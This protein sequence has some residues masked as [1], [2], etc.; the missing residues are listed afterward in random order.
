[1]VEWHGLR[2][3]RRLR[4]AESREDPTDAFGGLDIPVRKSE[5]K[6]RQGKQPDGSAK[7]RELK[8]AAV[9]SAE[10]HNSQDVLERD[11][12]PVSYTSAVESIATRDTDMA[13]SR[14]AR[15]ILREL[16]RRGF[17]DVERS[18]VLG[19]SYALDLELYVEHLPD[20][21]QIVDIAGTPVSTLPRRG[22]PSATRV[23]PGTSATS[24]F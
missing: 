15:R 4:T 8:L 14:F 12:G 19:D 17:D 5:T 21:V 23:R 3:E 10:E 6:G 13:L 24:V 16:E 11:P 20:A 9:W 2:N 7:T 22:A 1:M 18:V